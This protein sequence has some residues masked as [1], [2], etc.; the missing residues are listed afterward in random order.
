MRRLFF[1]VFLSVACQT[2]ERPVSTGIFGEGVTLGV[3]A[4]TLSEASGL[5][6]SLRH[7]GYLWTMN[8]SGNKPAVYLINRRGEVVMTCMLTGATNRDWEGL[9]L[10]PTA[11]TTVGRLVVGDIGDNRARYDSK[12][13]YEF[14]EP[15][16]DSG[17]VVQVS[18]Q[19]RV[20]VLPDGARDS[21]TLLC[22][23]RKDVVYLVSKRERKVGLYRLEP[24]RSPDS[25]VAKRKATLDVHEV[26][27][28]SIS[29]NGKEILL[30]T[31]SEI[32]YWSCPDSVSLE[33]CLQQPAVLLPYQREL[34]GEGIAF[35]REGINY[36]TVSESPKVHRG[37]LRIYRRHRH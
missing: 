19:K 27:D 37:D 34:Q 11:D 4:P 28:G 6:A 30:R 2:K 5:V 3:L 14:D 20:V 33:T 17:Q 1:L 35:D 36:F 13:L 24:T 31:Y 23:A 22:D 32:L 9:A 25:L 26:T 29:W 21:E 15:S 16:L 8:D 10:R 18:F 12:F 7:P